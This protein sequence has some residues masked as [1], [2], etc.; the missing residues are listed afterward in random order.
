[1]IL[2][3]ILLFG[4]LLN[5][6]A[7]GKGIVEVDDRAF[8]PKIVILST[9][10][11]GNPVNIKLSRNFPLNSEVRIDE[12]F[13]DEADA[14]IVDANGTTYDLSFNSETFCFENS[15]LMVEFGHTYT[16][17]VKATIDGK[18]LFAK[19]TTTVPQAGFEVLHEKSVLDSMVY[20]ERDENNELK[21]FE[22]VFNRS[23][24]TDFYAVSL[25]AIDADTTTFIY[26]NPFNDNDADDVNFY[27]DDLKYTFTWI[28]DTPK[29]AGESGME[30]FWFLTSFYDNYQAVVY[31]ADKN[32]KDFLLTHDM[33]QEIDGNFHE[34]S[35]HIEGDGIGLFGSAVAETV[36]FKILRDNN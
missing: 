29:V 26:D 8:Q 4:F 6:F 23:P 13:L 20:R 25:T 10:I 5:L 21:R 33:V 24:G 27:F 12:L 11:P 22:V 16:L 36:Y 9:L 28:Q 30:V 15:N 14:K 19:S 31:A 35:F 32:F 1:M 2:K 18:E 7:C 34:P 3:R 17:E